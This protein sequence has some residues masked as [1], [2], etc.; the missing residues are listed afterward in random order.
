METE[1]NKSEPNAPWL[2]SYGDVPF[3]LSYPQGSISDAVF[4]TAEKENDYPALSYMGKNF[5][6]KTL[7]AKIDAAAAGF[8]ALGVQKG[9]VVTICM[10]NVPQAV[11]MMYAL[12]RIGAIA[13]MIHPLSAVKEIVYYLNEV[14]S[15]MIV[16][17]DQFYNKV[18]EVEK[19]YALDKVIITSAA[20]ELG[21]VK[22]SLFKFM[23]RKK[24]KV[25]KDDAK[26]VT[27]SRFIG[28]G[29]KVD[30]TS[31][32][33]KM[34]ADDVA[35]ILFSGGTTGVTKAIQ[36]S[37]MNFN[38]LGMQTEAMCNVTVRHKRMLAAMPI[39][40]GFGLGV[41]IH[42]MLEAGGTSI[43]VPQFNAKSYSELIKKE[44]PNFIAG[45]PTLLEAITRN[46]YLDGEKLDYL[47]G[48]FSGGDSL[49]VEL[50]KRFDA[51]LESH[52]A[53]IHVRE[54]YGTTECVTASCLTP[55]NQ[56]REGS[57]G[58]PYPDTYYTIC[59]VG[60][61]D[62]V[63]YGQLGEICLRGPSVMV[64]YFNHE[65]E[66]KN[67][68]R[69]HD[70]GYTWLHTGDLG[71]MDNEG[72]I[73]FKQRIKRM[74]ITS[75][76]NVYPSQLENIIDAHEAVQMSCVIGVKDEYKMQKVKAYVVLKE[77]FTPSANLK[78]DILE[79][80]RLHIAKYAMPYDIEFREELPKT[81]VGKI[82]YTV[83]EK[84][85][86]AEFHAA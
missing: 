83:L 81:L 35:V 66:N 55:Y 84:E 61:N 32:L 38:A 20:D 8:A 23:N 77:G 17:L 47:Q 76:Y 28:D 1:F 73:Y 24:K 43:L 69:V 62:T 79:Y 57:I 78:D 19:E 40:H 56:E 30:L 86:N 22:S 85:A 53:T 67:T 71:Y 3:H 4:A 42:T 29:K 70:D 48:V 49:S 6:Y 18:S 16:T 15:K 25:N 27:W 58:F 82:A 7:T 51:F 65:E 60:T 63:P 11:Y 10:P 80:C 39:F 14:N 13:S 41:C 45:V 31:K 2:D 59:A 72:F 54:G 36:L 34:N 12:N 75:G 64:G 21:V 44:K 52:G 74:I 50:K 5:S 9:D 37:S 68:L 26:L 33:V 46:S